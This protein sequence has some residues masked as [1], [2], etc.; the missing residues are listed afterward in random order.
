MLVALTGPTG[1][2]RAIRSSSDRSPG[3]FSFRR[4][5]NSFP[6]RDTETRFKEAASTRSLIPT[7]YEEDFSEKEEVV[8]PRSTGLRGW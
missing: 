3:F 5:S 4:V 7:R 6:C 1:M 8:V 2:P